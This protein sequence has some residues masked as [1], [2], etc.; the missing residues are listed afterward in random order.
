MRHEH[1]GLARALLVQRFQDDRLVQAVEIARRLVKEH[2]R[3]V[4]QKRAGES[5]A[6]AFAARKRVAQLADR[7]VVALR[8]R[9]DEFVHGG[10]FAGRDDLVVR[11]V[12]LCDA[13]VIFD[14]VV[15]EM[16]LLR[17][18]ALHLAQIPRV[19]AGNVRA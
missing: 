14:A 5:E 8:Q 15:E 4:V 18:E 11:R 17:D 10:L 6:L 9:H 13:E 7:R 16:R 3:R 1:D 19:D 2:Q 12:E